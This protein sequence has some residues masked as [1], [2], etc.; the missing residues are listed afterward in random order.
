MIYSETINGENITDWN[1]FHTEFK[2]KMGFFSGYGENTNAWIDCMTDMYT[3]NEYN[4]LTKFNLNDG[5]QFILRVINSEKWKKQNQETFDAFIEYSIWSN[6][7][8]TNFLLEL[9]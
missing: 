4:S 2:E 1:S 8:K 6:N 9:K 5:D 7:E 3:N